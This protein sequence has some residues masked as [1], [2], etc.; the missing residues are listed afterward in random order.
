[1]IE[2][3]G[4]RTESLSDGIGIRTVIYFQKCSHHCF[5]CQNPDTW[6]EGKGQQVTLQYLLNIIDNDHLAVGVTF[7]GGCPM[8]KPEQII[9]LAKEIKKRNK[10]IWCYCGEKIGELKDKQLE[11]LQYIDVLIDGEY[12]DEL[13]DDTL[14]FRGSKNQKIHKITEENN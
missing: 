6:E 5:N 11:L 1:M 3:A 7:S 12:I 4:V 10:N 2:I 9:E 14:A 13:R 8:C